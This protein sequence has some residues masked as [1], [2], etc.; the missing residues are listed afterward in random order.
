MNTRLFVTLLS[1]V[2]EGGRQ[3]GN[4]RGHNWVHYPEFKLRYLKNQKLFSIRVKELFEP[5]VLHRKADGFLLVFKAF[6][7][8]PDLWVTLGDFTVKNVKLGT[9][10]FIE[11]KI[12]WIEMKRGLRQIITIVCAKGFLDSNFY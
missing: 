12:D 3:A 10:I 9:E 6:S 2:G 4:L 11:L 5:T 7:W 8:E 1:W